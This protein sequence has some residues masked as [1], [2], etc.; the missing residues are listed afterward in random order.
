MP[1]G[2]AGFANSMNAAFEEMLAWPARPHVP[3]RIRSEAMVGLGEDPFFA[4]IDE[5]REKEGKAGNGA[6]PC[7][8][9]K[10]Y[11]HSSVTRNGKTTSKTSRRFEDESGRRIERTER[12]IGGKS[13][14]ETSRR[15]N[16]DGEPAVERRVIFNDRQVKSQG[17]EETDQGV[18][19]EDFDAEWDR[20]VFGREDSGALQDA[21][22][23]PMEREGVKST[24]AEGSP[25]DT[26]SKSPSSMD[27]VQMPREEMQSQQPRHSQTDGS[28]WDSRIAHLASMHQ[29]GLLTDEEF[30]AAKHAN[31]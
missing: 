18:L 17:Q 28:V 7:A 29:Q 30:L 14:I 13:M 4:D 10:V 5:E 25:S 15:E 8:S 27:P 23:T 3:I 11:S 31:V 2:Q 26:A 12:K 20:G 22:D 9:V 16:L 24:P 19:V 1:W 21:G 6:S